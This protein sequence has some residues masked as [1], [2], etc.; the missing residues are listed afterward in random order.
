MGAIKQTLLDQ[1]KE[2]VKVI[3][4]FECTASESGVRK[5]MSDN[6]LILL[7]DVQDWELCAEIVFSVPYISAAYDF[8]SVWFL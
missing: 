7:W 5:L 3:Q 1:S 6:V 4:L 2:I 8:T